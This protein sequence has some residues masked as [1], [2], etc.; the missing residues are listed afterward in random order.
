MV[1]KAFVNLKLDDWLGSFWSCFENEQ[2][3]HI[4]ISYIF[5]YI[6][7]YIWG[8]IL[9]STASY[10][11][12]SLY[13]CYVETLRKVFS[14]TVMP[15]VQEDIITNANHTDE[16]LKALKPPKKYLPKK[17]C[18]LDSKLNVLTM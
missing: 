11:N 17:L 1:L 2:G 14:F 9:F 5:I 18:I 7:I 10:I 12:E 15:S 4:L 3:E 8:K 16:I 13:S 6:Y